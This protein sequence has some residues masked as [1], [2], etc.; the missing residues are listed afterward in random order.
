MPQD[1][2]QLTALRFFAALWVVLYHFWPSLGAAMPALVGKGYLGVEL[3]FTLSGFIL[4]HVYLARF[5][6]G[7]FK[8]RE[9]LWAR[10]AR[11]YPMH[12]VT[13]LGLG[14]LALAATAAGVPSAGSKLLIWPS[15]IPNLLLVQAWGFAPGGGWNHPSWSISAEWFAYL[16]FPLFAAAAWAMRDRPRLAMGA[17]VALL[18]G[19][20]EGFQRLAGFPLTEA[21]I[22]WGALRIVPCF[23]LG[24]AAHLLWRAGVLKSVR[25]A[26]GAALGGLLAAALFAVLGAPDWA[27]VTAFSVMILGLAAM[28]ATGSRRLTAPVWVYLGEVSFAIYMVCIPWML[29][30]HNGSQKL[31]HLQ[32]DSLPLILW[33]PMLAG[34]IPAAMVLHHGVERPARELMRRYGAPFARSRDR[35]TPHAGEPIFQS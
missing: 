11:V 19:L 1:L 4:C 28:S 29:V 15:L 23:A 14:A 35:A 26:T 32:G 10:L 31:F 5:G 17:A 7:G 20:Y 9:F 21:T 6:Q 27:S 2:K 3:F 12:L 33:I 18:I 25:A 8:Y 13:L 16:S 24:C 22:A 34:V 30:F